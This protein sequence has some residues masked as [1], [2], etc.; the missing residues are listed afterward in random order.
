MYINV[1]NCQASIVLDTKEILDEDQLTDEQREA[2]ETLKKY[3]IYTVHESA[4]NRSGL[5]DFNEVAEDILD[6]VLRGNTDAVNAIRALTEEDI[7]EKA[8]ELIRNLG[9]KELVEV[10]NSRIAYGCSEFCRGYHNHQ[11][12]TRIGGALKIVDDGYGHH[13]GF[14]R[15]G[16][17]VT[18]LGVSTSDI[19]EE[20]AL[21][22]LVEYIRTVCDRYDYSI[23][24]V[25]NWGYEIFSYDD[26]VEE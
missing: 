20:D 2:V 11:W 7:S 16:R 26:L 9:E 13:H 24:E 12:L 15:G 5:Y 10:E 21:D 17:L 18:T 23:Y 3:V 6:D 4:I 19:T 8:T 14:S 25:K 22:K 1:W